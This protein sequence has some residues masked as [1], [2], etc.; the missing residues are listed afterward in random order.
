MIKLFTNIDTMSTGSTLSEGKG[1][2]LKEVSVARPEQLLDLVC[3]SCPDPS[4]R[5]PVVAKATLWNGRVV[6]ATYCPSGPKRQ[7]PD[8]QTRESEFS[9]PEP[10]RRLIDRLL[11]TDQPFVTI[12]GTDDMVCAL[13]WTIGS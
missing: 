5:G 9:D 3:E 1:D 4:L 13:E 12:T 8:A 6:T 2:D 10:L 7:N 11:L